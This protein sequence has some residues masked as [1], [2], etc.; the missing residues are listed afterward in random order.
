MYQLSGAFFVLKYL[1]I[2]YV[3]KFLLSYV[4]ETFKKVT[5]RLKTYWS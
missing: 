1:F 3:L 5:A 2:L 4:L